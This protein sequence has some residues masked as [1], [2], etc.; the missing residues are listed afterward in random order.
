MGSAYLTLSG[1][2]ICRIV[3]EAERVGP[4]FSYGKHKLLG[5]CIL[6]SEKGRWNEC[7]DLASLPSVKKDL[8]FCEDSCQYET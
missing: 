4:L 3:A 8:A 1:E 7:G 6:P 2:V 5:L